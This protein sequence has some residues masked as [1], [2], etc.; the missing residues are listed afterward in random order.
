[1]EWI[2]VREQKPP[3]REWVL[4]GKYFGE[5]ED[6]DHTIWNIGEYDADK[7]SYNFLC[8]YHDT[9]NGMGAYTSHTIAEFHP[10]TATHW[11]ALPLLPEAEVK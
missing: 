4:L 5:S 10:N 3:H 7:E 2:S 9:C 11:M 6:P 1:M 8:Q